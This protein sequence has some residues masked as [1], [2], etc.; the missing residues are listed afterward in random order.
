MGRFETCIARSRWSRV[1]RQRVVL[2]RLLRHTGVPDGPALEIG[3][4]DGTTSSILLRQARSLD[5][6]ATDIDPEVLSQAAHRLAGRA[7]VQMADA[8][9]L[10]FLPASFATVLELNV[11]HHVDDFPRALR[12]IARVL[13]PEGTFLFVD[14]TA[15]AHARLHVE[16]VFDAP[17]FRSALAQAGLELDFMRGD[18]VIWGR[19][20]K[21]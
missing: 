3:C 7:R 12:E 19:A 15:R 10:P 21:P 8:T 13:R 2:P 17:T 18:A 5:L 11:L 6:V 9:E 20:R 16:N 1:Y 4:G 14:H